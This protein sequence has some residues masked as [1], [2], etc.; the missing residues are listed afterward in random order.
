MQRVLVSRR[1]RRFFAALYLACVLVFLFGVA[2][3]YRPGLG[4]TSMLRFGR[5]FE[6][7]VIPELRHAPRF[8]VAK[9]GY[10]GQFYA[11]LA[12]KPVPWDPD[13]QRALD[14]PLYRSGRI[15]PSLVAY[16][17][18]GGN[19]VRAMHVFA[20]MNVVIW[21]GLAWLLLYWFPA[22]T[23][24]DFVGWAGILFSAGTMMCVCRALP[25]FSAFVLIVAALRLWEG[26]RRN[27]A[28]GVLGLAG[29]VRETSIL[30]AALVAEKP[31]DR[32]RALAT[33]GRVTAAVLPALALVLVLRLVVVARAS[34][35]ASNNFGLPLMG[36][37]R[38]FAQVADDG[39]VK[40]AGVVATMA[41]IVVQAGFFV[42]RPRLTEARFRLGLAY[43]ILFLFTN[44]AIWGGYPGSAPR[45]LLP[46]LFAFN[47]ALPRSARLWPLL[48]LGNLSVVT[49][50]H[51][52]M[53][54]PEPA[55]ASQSQLGG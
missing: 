18:A 39:L 21:C 6:S 29:F 34:H 17:L 35:A 49:G 20:G 37:L 15:V 50:W 48:L 25:D 36:M 54:P 27:A 26:G 46:L 13:V 14:D 22:G 11:Q 5:D 12:A 24:W 1:A 31:S 38:R 53:H 28:G 51:N 42:V 40:S 47:L 55:P 2:R 52:L 9:T 23:A 7:R 43:V 30:A 19:P 10:D 45:V 41:S 44:D 8:V 33:L 16:T 4:L 3:F 32:K